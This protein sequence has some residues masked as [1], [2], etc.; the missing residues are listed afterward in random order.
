[1]KDSKGHGS[2]PRGAHSGGVQQVGV[3]P[4]AHLKQKLTGDGVHVWR[5]VNSQRRPADPGDFGSGTY[6]S[7]SRAR[8]YE[9]A[10]SAGSLNHTT[11]TFKNP[12]VL[13][14]EDAYKF[15]DRF[16]TLHGTPAQRQANADALRDH[17]VAR[18][19]D[20][21]VSVS[22]SRDGRSELEVVDYRGRKSR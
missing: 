14:T 8:A 10:G 12:L 7:T 11:L 5:G 22:K 1:M 9:Y 19:H 21:L 3:D 20:G 4:Y 2:D 16:D 6:H 13:S 18:G 17:I 15:Q